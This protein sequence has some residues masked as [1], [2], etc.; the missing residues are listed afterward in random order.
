MKNE[1]LILVVNPGS[2][3]RKY[4]LFSD[5]TKKANI[6]FEFEN[7][8]VI[9][10]LDYNGQKYP[11]TYEDSDLSAVSRYVFPI[12]KQYQI[13]SQD[14]QLSAIGIRLVAPSRL[15]MK[16]AYV[17]ESIM[18]AMEAVQARAP[19]HVG[20][21]LTEIKQ[22]TGHFVGTPIIVISDS[23]FHADKPSKAW[24]Y[25]ID[26]ELAEKL[27]V[28]RFGYHGISVGSVVR[29]L[30]E[31]NQLLPKTIVCHIGSGSSITAVRDG[32][33]VETSMGY[34][35]LEGLMMSTRCGTMDISAALAI[36]RGLNMSDEQLEEYLNKKAGLLGLS[37][38]SDDIR[39]L[40]EKENDGDER[41][42]LALDIFVYRVQLAI[43]QMA[44]SMGG[45]DQLVFTA[46]VGERS[47]PMRQR[48]TDNLGYLGFNLNQETN[49]NAFEPKEITNIAE[50]GG[51]PILVVST[52][53]SSEIARRATE[54]IRLE[55]NH[56]ENL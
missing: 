47:A 34:T 36:K 24:H 42:K 25:G 19:L 50:S 49:N 22:L 17:D 13:V 41:A 52:D 6:N 55:L 56:P 43:G 26:T 44:A 40:L 1:S 45:A 54:Y 11:A 27:D 46:T 38:S 23:A 48:I 28:R 31:Q 30:S 37:G 20:T 53:E 4:A 18:Q 33:S 16:D 32:K 8:K 15:F 7:G 21:V 3:S 2:A 39:Q 35:P 29:I 12:L 51:K 9:S 10:K 5:G 14:S